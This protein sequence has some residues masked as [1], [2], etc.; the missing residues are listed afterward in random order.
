M[1]R[2]SLKSSITTGESQYLSLIAHTLRQGEQRRGRNGVTYSVLGQQMRFCL[3][4][5]RIPLLTTKKVAWKTCLKEL[6]WFISGST[7]NAILNK[8]NVHI[9]NANASRE[10]LQGRNLSYTK[11]GDLGPIYGHQWRYFNAPYIDCDTDYQGQGIDQLQNIINGLKEDKYSRRHVLSAWNPCQLDQMALPPCHIMCQFLVN[12]ANELSC[13]LYQRSGDL[14]LGIP[15]NIASYS[16]LLCLLAQH[17][18]LRRGELI[19]FIGDAH[20]YEEH[21]SV[22][23]AQLLREI[24]PS[25]ILQIYNTYANINDYTIKDFVL[26]DYRHHPSLLMKM[27]A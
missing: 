9:W 17:C 3:R 8:Q 25:P 11:K 2:K 4:N 7:N 22:L 15:F 18:A 24:Y 26:K 10:F 27:I 14:G 13:I 23:Q 6:F 16:F 20:I 21:R 5:D 12:S 19:H 1:M